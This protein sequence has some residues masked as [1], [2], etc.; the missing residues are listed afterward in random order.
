MLLVGLNDSKAISFNGYE[1][2]ISSILFLFGCFRNLILI[3]CFRSMYILGIFNRLIKYNKDT[4]EEFE[5]NDTEIMETPPDND[6]INNTC[7]TSIPSDACD[8]CDIN[9]Y[10]G[11]TNLLVHIKKKDS[12]R[13]GDI[14]NDGT[15]LEDMYLGEIKAKVAEFFNIKNIHFLFGAGVSSPATPIMKGLYRS[16]VLKIVR[17]KNEDLDKY[18]EAYKEFRSIRNR[19]DDKGNLEE[20]LGI[21]Y[22]NRT[23]LEGNRNKVE[24]YEVCTNLIELIEEDIFN[25]INADLEKE[26]SIETLG[27]YKAFYQKLAFRNRDLSRLNIFT[28]NNDLFNEHALDSLNINYINGFSGGLNCYFNPA[29]YNHTFSKRMDTSIERYEPVDN[30]VNLF[31]IH[32]SVNWIEDTKKENSFFKIKEIFPPKREKEG[33]VLIY[34]TPTKQNKSLGSPYVE[35]F[36]EFQRRLLLPHSVLFVIGYSFSDEHVNNI[37]YQALATNSSIN[38][39]I[40]NSLNK[41]AISES[42]D[43]RIFRIWGKDSNGASIHYFNYLVN[44]LLPDKD[45]NTSQDEFLNRFITFYNDKLKK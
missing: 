10:Q 12:Q 41:N 9:F 7:D 6:E 43:K 13:N 14:E 26:A 3:I 44:N 25:N 37:I 2:R 36:R 33:A 4:M 35:L 17:E 19:V 39:V 27:Y 32:G 29:M 31:K 16:V 5:N 18:G 15:T 20:I 23:Y 21:L 11:Q 45:H 38:V 42:D 28:T 22:A 24:E 30:V 34:P 8:T 1:D 40:L